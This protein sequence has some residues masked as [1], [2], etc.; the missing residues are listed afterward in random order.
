[1]STNGDELDDGP[2]EPTADHGRA[3]SGLVIPR[4]RHLVAAYRAWA[5]DRAARLGAA[6]AYYCLFALIPVLFLSISLAGL[7]FGRDV[8]GTAVEEAIADVLGSGIAS[9]VTAAIDLLRAESSSGVLPLVSF[10]A[11]LFTASLLFV[12]WKELV[13][14]VW[15][16]P[17]EAGIAAGAARRVFGVAVVVGAGLLLAAMIFAEVILGAVDRF[18]EGPA[19]DAL[20]TVA[21]SAAPLVLGSVFLMALL[22]LT[23]DRQVRWQAAAPAAV[24]SMLLLSVEAWAYGWYL[25]SFGFASATGV[26]GSLLLGLAF[27][28][29]AA[30]TLLYG[31]ELSKVLETDGS[32]RSDAGASER[33][34]RSRASSVESPRSSPEKV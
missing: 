21:G 17:R 30:Q 2:S 6:L 16:V 4:P 3:P 32:E 34:R 25:S 22:E 12:A 33:P 10:G 15:D 28:Y 27:L 23:P 29:Y 8:A 18:V 1:M 11:L 19:L 26:A 20:V 5:S 31:V 9:Q 14:L 24:L 7:L 13:D